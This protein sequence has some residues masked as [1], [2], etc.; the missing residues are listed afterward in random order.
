MQFFSNFSSARESLRKSMQTAQMVH[1]GTWQG[2]DISH[3]PEAKMAEICFTSFQV[4]MT[5]LLFD[6]EELGKQ[7]G[8]NLPWAEDHFLERVCG[9]PINPGIQWAKW[10]WGHSADGFRDANGQFNHNYM[11]RY[12]P[13]QGGMFEIPTD[14]PEQFQASATEV[15]GNRRPDKMGL[16]YRYGDLN[17]LVDLFIRDPLTRQGY[18]PIFFPEDTGAHHGSRVP[19]TLG[20]HFMLRRDKLHVTYYI[21]SC[22]L[23]RHFDDDVYLTV[24]L[25]WWLLE[26]LREADQRFMKVVP[27][28]FMM[29]IGSLH[30][31]INDL[32]QL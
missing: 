23:F 2:V 15:W 9:E 22:D 16:R 5:P 12:W 28:L 27:G 3:R 30:C 8:A 6:K 1:T 25:V 7:T 32:R 19:C 4:P 11:E 17:D 10:P 31:F 21:R 29:H 13:R 18:L 14:T 26:Q 20:Y 24:R